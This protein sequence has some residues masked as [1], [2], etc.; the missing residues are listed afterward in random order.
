MTTDAKLSNG[1]P[2]QPHE[3]FGP[4]SDIARSHPDQV[5]GHF[6]ST[7]F[8]AL[9]IFPM[10]R[11]QYMLLNNDSYRSQNEPLDLDDIAAAVTFLA[12]VK[13]PHYVF[14]NCTKDAGY[15]RLHKHMQIMKKPEVVTSEP[16]SFRFFP[17]ARDPEV[18]VRYRY[19]LQNFDVAEALESEAVY[20]V[21]LGLLGQCRHALGIESNDGDTLC[22]HIM[23]LVK[24]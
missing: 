3:M 15:S 10:F 17:D 22:P 8:L 20:E 16:S 23:V 21:Y 19:F 5:V 11:P 4:G 24:E 14:Y 13:D 12:S 2:K 9:N 6:N 1:N 7:H 18:R